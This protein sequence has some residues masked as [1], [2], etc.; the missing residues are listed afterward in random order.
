MVIP[1]GPDPFAVLGI[2]PRFDLDPAQLEARFRERSREVHP[3]RFAGASAGTRAAALVQ[4][5]ALNDAYQVLRKPQ[6]RAEHL[7]GRHGIAIDDRERL[8]PGFLMEILE[9]REELAEA[10]AAGELE[11]VNLLAADMRARQRAIVEGLTR[12]FA[13]LD[14]GDDAAVLAAIKHDLITMRYVGRYV[15][16]C[17]A[18]LDAADE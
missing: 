9:R 3:D 11:R 14:G 13:A 5:R 7:L 17:D 10:R 16:E 2:E 18:A 4:T 1:S 6:R 12:H 8:D 15:D